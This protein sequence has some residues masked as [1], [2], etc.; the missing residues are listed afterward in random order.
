M[1]NRFLIVNGHPDPGARR[2][3]AALCDSYEVGVKSRG[4]SVERLDIGSIVTPSSIL[5]QESSAAPLLTIDCAID[6]IRKADRI[7]VVFPLW[8]GAAPH[9]LQLLFESVARDANLRRPPKPAE[10]V[11]T[12]DMPAIL[13]RSQIAAH[14]KSVAAKNPF[15]LQ[16]LRVAQATLI[17][18]VNVMAQAERERWLGDVRAIA[19]L[20]VDRDMA[21][22]RPSVL[23]WRVPV[24]LPA[25]LTQAISRREPRVASWR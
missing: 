17:G 21:A 24:A 5:A 20:A 14:R 4:W 8:L 23:G 11:V 19:G 3:C 25:W 1:E 2:Y 13:Y 9:A 12:M 10:L 7:A 6:R 22:R 15:Y 16:G 18:S